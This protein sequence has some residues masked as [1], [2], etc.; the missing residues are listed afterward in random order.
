MK[1]VFVIVS[2]MILFE[3][4]CHAQRV[5]SKQNLEHASL[6]SLNSSLE[7]A[8]KLKKT[9][10]ILSIAGPVSFVAGVLLGAA[11]WSGGTEAMWQVGAG[12]IIIGTFTTVIGL[13][14]L[15]TNSSRVKKV[16]NAINSR[17]GASLNLTPCFVYNSKSQFLSPGLALQIRF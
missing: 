1:R 4:T 8:Q 3:F 17:T 14:I 9:G 10:A 6:E 13:P 12:M 5:Y 7:K 2:L 16:R 11:A 15:I